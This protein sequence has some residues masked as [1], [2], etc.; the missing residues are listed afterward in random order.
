MSTKITSL[1]QLVDYYS[2]FV[3]AHL[4]LKDF[5]YGSTWDIG[6]SNQMQFPYLWVT[7]STTSSISVSANKTQIPT[8]TLSF[9][10][11]DQWNN[12]ENF[13][14]TN[15]DNSNNA[16]EILSDTMQICQDIITYTSVNLRDFGVM[17]IAGDVTLDPIIDETPDKVWGWKLDLNLQL[18]HTNCAMPGDFTNV[19]T[20]K[21]E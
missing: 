6:T 19:P 12:Q 11:V 9:L 8:V 16:Q 5:G 21:P 7:H 4:Q 17:M 1:N 3:D 10:V 15:G 13:E 14:D 20:P 2:Q 18:T